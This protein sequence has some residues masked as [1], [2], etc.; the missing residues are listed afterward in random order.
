M[1]EKTFEVRKDDEIADI[2][3]LAEMEDLE[4]YRSGED[5]D[6]DDEATL[7]EEERL[8]LLESGKT[9][10]KLQAEERAG[11]ERDAEVPLEDLLPPG[12][13]PVS[14]MMD[15]T[16]NLPVAF[17]A[18]AYMLGLKHILGAVEGTPKAALSAVLASAVVGG[19]FNPKSMDWV[20]WV[21]GTAVA[22]VGANQGF[23]AGMVAWAV[24][25]LVGVGGV[26]KRKKH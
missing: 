16:S 11:L 13:K 10:G 22:A 17:N 23:A 19:V 25:D 3:D 6:A 24:R 18:L 8:A 21:T 20:G 9:L 15:V 7:E 26:A 1:K 2:A 12:Y 4:E 14:V 5:D